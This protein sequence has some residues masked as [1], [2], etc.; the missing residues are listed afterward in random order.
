M[1]RTNEAG[2]RKKSFPSVFAPLALVLAGVIAF[3]VCWHEY[4]PGAVSSDAPARELAIEKAN[5][6]ATT[7]DDDRQ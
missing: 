5:D 3:L 4:G 1:L 6:R 2:R 7:A